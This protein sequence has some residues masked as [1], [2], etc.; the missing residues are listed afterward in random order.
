MRTW[1]RST[2]APTAWCADLP[3][4]RASR[5]TALESALRHDRFWVCGALLLAVLL[6]WAWI[7]PMARDMYGPMD[8]ASAWMARG[9]G[10]AAYPALLFAMWLVMMAGMMLPSAA[11]T[12]LLYAA[13]IRKSTQGAR[14]AA[15]LYAFAA[16]YV[17]AWGG[18]SLAATLAQLWLDRSLQLS[19]MLQLRSASLGGAVLLAAG[20]WQLT[21]WK[22][23]CLGSCRAPAA[24]IA[25]HWR[26]G[27][28]GALHMGLVNGGFCLGC[29]WALMLLLFVGG[30][31]NLGWIALLTVLV[32]L[33]KLAP[34]GLLGARLVGLVLLLC[35]AA[36][37]LHGRGG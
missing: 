30:V 20:A 4:P 35:G 2:G 27:V 28:G 25:G 32:L 33:E 14:T 12:L 18:F 36:L 24:F 21:P 15:H 29:C 7:V 17:L 16:G 19:A 13:V 1:R 26:P 11:P 8:G 3:A 10:S 23:A 5:V 34:Y 6:C 37:L 31:M 22:Q 9:S